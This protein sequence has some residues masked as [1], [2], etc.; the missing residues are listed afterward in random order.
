MANYNTFVV[1]DCKSRKNKLITSSARKA[2][3]ELCI[4]VKVEVWNDN[5]HTETIYSR[6]KKNLERYI[7]LEKQ[8]IAAKQEKANLKNQR[9]KST[10]KDA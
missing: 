7:S 1:Y 9:R 10:Q 6:S 3:N 4:G 2:R 5:N 8:Y